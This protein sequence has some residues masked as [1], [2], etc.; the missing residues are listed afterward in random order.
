MPSPRSSLALVFPLLL[1]AHAARAEVTTSAAHRLV[2]EHKLTSTVA[3]AAL[4]RAIGQVGKWWNSQHT[5]SGSAANLSLRVDAGGCFCER[6]KQGSVEH[7]RVILVKRD[8]VVQIA[9]AMG[10]LMDLGVTGVLTFELKARPAEGGQA[11]GTDLAVTYKVGGDPGSALTALAGP[12]DTV[13][14][15]QAARLVK[16]AQTGKPD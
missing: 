14:G 7:G 5:F 12:V 9:T 10:P 15:E 16:F 11:A 2:V 3:P 8:Q 6:W 1:L 4:F 13:I